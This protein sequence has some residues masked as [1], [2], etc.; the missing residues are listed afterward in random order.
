MVMNI[1][2]I[3]MHVFFSLLSVFHGYVIATRRMMTKTKLSLFSTK[4]AIYTDQLTIN[5]SVC[6]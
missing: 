6:L 3:N 5:L 1:W 4:L 2:R